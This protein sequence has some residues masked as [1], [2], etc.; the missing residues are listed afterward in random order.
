MR[1]LLEVI[2]TADRLRRD[3]GAATAIEYTM[4]AGFLSIMIAGPAYLI[5]QGI[6]INYFEKIVAA[7]PH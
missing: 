5:G 7:F 3:E 4:I 6:L 1:R 2:A